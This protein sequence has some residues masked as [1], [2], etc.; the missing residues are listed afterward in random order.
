M[1]YYFVS[2]DGDYIE[3]E[4]APRG[5]FESWQGMF[6]QK[7]LAIVEQKRRLKARIEELKS[8]LENLNEQHKRYYR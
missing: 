1:I 5:Y 8:T 6:T 4:E 3:T 7:K 2:Q